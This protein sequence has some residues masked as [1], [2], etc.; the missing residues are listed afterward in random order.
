MRITYILCILERVI[1][2]GYPDTQV[3]VQDQSRHSSPFQIEVVS[4]DPLSLQAA[5]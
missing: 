3:Y 2:P 5:T 4:N 1:Y